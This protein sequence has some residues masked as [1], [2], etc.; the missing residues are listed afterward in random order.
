MFVVR[1]LQNNEP[2]QVQIDVAQERPRGNDIGGST[3]HIDDIA[4]HRGALFRRLGLEPNVIEMGGR[5]R[6]QAVKEEH[7]PWS[8]HQVAYSSVVLILRVPK[9][10]SGRLHRIGRALTWI[11]ARE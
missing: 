4:V 1:V 11:T 7:H 9:A 8:E 6:E 5:I 3:S 2:T 10:L